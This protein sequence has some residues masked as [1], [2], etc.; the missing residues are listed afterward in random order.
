MAL[1]SGEWE[2]QWGNWPS[3]VVENSQVPMSTKA[4]SLLGSYPSEARTLHIHVKSLDFFWGSHNSE[5]GL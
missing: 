1:P 3:P 4:K 5:L 2:L